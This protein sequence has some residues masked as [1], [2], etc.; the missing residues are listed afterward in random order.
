MKPIRLPERVV[1]EA[2]V[3]E[4]HLILEILEERVAT[5]LVPVDDPRSSDTAPNP[6]TKVTVNKVDSKG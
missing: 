3:N 4:T 6:L 1:R 5:A 2:G